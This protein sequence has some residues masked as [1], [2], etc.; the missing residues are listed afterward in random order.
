MNKIEIFI[1]FLEIFR[2]L[3]IYK[4]NLII[5]DYIILGI[6]I[7]NFLEFFDMIIIDLGNRF[8]NEGNFYFLNFD[9]MMNGILR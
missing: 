8:L 2:I 7:Y 4:I 5:E 3:I 6:Y 9:F 1:D